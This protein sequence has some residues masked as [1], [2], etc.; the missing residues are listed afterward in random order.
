MIDSLAVAL[1]LGAQDPSFWMPLVFMALFYGIVVAGTVLDGFDIGVGCL[2][3]FAPRALR[4][5][6]LSL[7]SPWRDA[8][9]FW[10]FLGLGLFV[11]AFP[12]AWGHVMSA[13]YLPMCLLALGVLLR[14]VSFEMRLRAHKELQGRWLAGFAVGS[15]M[16]ALAHGALLAQIVV[17][18]QSRSGYLWFTVF[19][20]GCAVAAYCLLGAAWLIMRVAGELRARAVMWGRRAVRWVA[21]GTVA[22]SLVLAFDNPG[23][24]LKWSD[25]PRWPNIALLWGAMLLC[26]VSIEMCLQRMINRSY[27]TTALPFVLTLL[28]FLAVLGGLGYSFFPYL[29]LDDVTIWDAAASVGSLRL[30]LS[31]TI[32]ALPVALI[33]NIWVYRRMFG[34]SIPPAPPEYAG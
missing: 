20:A 15:L 14:S 10:L 16:T 29:V 24:F 18:Y 11:S 3:L 2:A 34:L 1:G 7:L 6:M 17:T 21:A 23:V 12:H 13:L 27:R 31:G 4:P 28:I 9:E 26:F 25:G 30:I 19:V 8:N 32:I 33:F 22:V 5:R